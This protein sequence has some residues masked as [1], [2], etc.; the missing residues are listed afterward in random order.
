MRQVDLKRYHTYKNYSQLHEFTALE[1]N[2]AASLEE[3]AEARRR[4]L[5]RKAKEV[6]QW[7]D[8]KKIES[9]TKFERINIKTYKCRNKQNISPTVNLDFDPKMVQ[10]DPKEVYEPRLRAQEAVTSY[11]ND[12][13]SVSA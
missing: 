4:E 12:I 5:T 1:G 3:R 10:T 13:Q 2:V 9:F 8:L 7:P 6:Q 11:M